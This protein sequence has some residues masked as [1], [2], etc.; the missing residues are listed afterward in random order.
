MDTFRKDVDAERLL[1]DSRKLQDFN[2]QIKAVFQGNFDEFL[3]LY[4]HKHPEIQ[5]D[6]LELKAISEYNQFLK[7][8]A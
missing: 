1:E 8:N 4:L 2:K 7:E 6:S 5:S 3:L